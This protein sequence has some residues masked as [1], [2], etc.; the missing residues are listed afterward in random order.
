MGRRQLLFEHA[1]E[2]D[3]TRLGEYEA[4]GGYASL[5]KAL[6]M[7]P[8]HVIEVRVREEDVADALHLG[9]REVAHAGSGVDQDLVVDEQAGGPEARTHAAA[10]PQNLD[11][12]R[13]ACPRQVAPMLAGFSR[14]GCYP[15]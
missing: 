7:E 13:G 5:K 14:V 6:R 4:V 11:P 15:W 3:L 9:Q 12:H 2:R 10:A 1:E 8:A